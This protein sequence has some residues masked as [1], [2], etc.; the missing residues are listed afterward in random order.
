M[1]ALSSFGSGG[2]SSGFWIQSNEL[3]LRYDVQIPKRVEEKLN[4]HYM[5]MCWE[6]SLPASKQAN[7]QTNKQNMWY[8]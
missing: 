6:D 5:M 4:T 2:F 7:K 1:Q 3:L 8:I